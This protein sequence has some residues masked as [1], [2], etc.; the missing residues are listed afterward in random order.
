MSTTFRAALRRAGFFVALALALP[1]VAGCR[2]YT[3]R[4]YWHGVGSAVYI[5]TPVYACISDANGNCTPKGGYL[6]LK[7]N[8]GRQSVRWSSTAAGQG[9]FVPL[10][11]GEESVRYLAIYRSG[12]QELSA[13]L[14]VEV[15]E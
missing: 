13:D 5:N 1:L 4:V 12:N 2:T 15:C 14:T 11:P 9:S 8:S 7:N 6:Y 3:S 10:S